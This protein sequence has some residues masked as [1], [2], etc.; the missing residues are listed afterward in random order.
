MTHFYQ[1]LL[2]YIFLIFV[3]NLEF[4]ICCEIYICLVYKASVIFIFL[5]ENFLL[6]EYISPN[7]TSIPII[8]HESAYFLVFLKRECVCVS[9]RECVCV[10][11]NLNQNVI[12]YLIK[13]SKKSFVGKYLLNCYSKK[14]VL[15]LSHYMFSYN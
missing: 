5:F 11:V 10:L 9:H 7:Q 1:H 4:L 2:F 14:F 13:N 15:V 6:I 12:Q 8:L 3:D